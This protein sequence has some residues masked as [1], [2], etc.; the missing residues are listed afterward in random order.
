[1]VGET[2]VQPVGRSSVLPVGGLR[3]TRSNA[4]T[5]LIAPCSVQV[6]PPAKAIS[7]GT[8]EWLFLP[9]L[10]FSHSIACDSFLPHGARQASLSFTITQSLL[11]F[12]CIEPVL[13]SNHLILCHPLL[14]L[15]SIFPSIRVF[16]ND[17]ALHIRWTSIGA[18]ASTLV[19]PMNIQDWFLFGLTALISLQSKGLSR[20]ISNTT[21]Q[22]HLFIGAQPS[23][24]SNLHPYITT[25][26]TIALTIRT[27]V[28]KVI[29]LLYF[30]STLFIYFIS[31]ESPKR[32]GLRITS[33]NNAL[34][35]TIVIKFYEQVLHARY[36][37]IMHY[38]I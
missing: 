33:H 19:L 25:G 29:S 12:M 30:I 21:V 23:L 18:S 6:P 13:P 5:M 36:C 38:L 31:L 34:I 20:V 1:M 10:L 27:F 11:K 24:W 26:K 15:P 28:G 7:N 3:P 37:I 16:S 9:L 14:L 35:I 8:N 32:N 4:P 22:K 17:S 2:G